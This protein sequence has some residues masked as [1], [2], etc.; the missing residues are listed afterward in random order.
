MRKV[1]SIFECQAETRVVMRPGNNTAAKEAKAVSFALWNLS[2]P[3][4]SHHLKF[5]PELRRI[6]SSRPSFS[7]SIVSSSTEDHFPI[8][9]RRMVKMRRRNLKERS[10]PSG[11]ILQGPVFRA[12]AKPMLA[13][14][15]DVAYVTRKKVLSEP[16]SEKI[17]GSA[18]LS[19]FKVV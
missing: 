16:L 3:D 11:M 7:N 9:V 18:V 6:D 12:L 15:T 4:S 8:K 10:L 17:G 5:A 2:V 1:F 13:V 19:S 14:K